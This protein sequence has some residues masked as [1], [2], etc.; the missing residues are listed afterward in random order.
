MNKTQFFSFILETT[1][2]NR[3]FLGIT[4]TILLCIACSAFIAAHQSGIGCLLQLLICAVTCIIIITYFFIQ[5]NNKLKQQQEQILRLQINPHFLF[6]ALNSIGDFVQQNEAV[7]A[8]QYLSS[9]SK[10]MRT[11]LENSTKEQISLKEELYNLELYLQL[12][13]SRLRQNFTYEIQVQDDL[14]IENIMV[15]PMILQP[16]IENSIWH[17]VSKVP[18]GKISVAVAQKGKQLE[19]RVYDNGPGYHPSN[20][21]TQKHKKSLGISISKERI[22]ACYRGL[23]LPSGYFQYRNLARGIMFTFRIPLIK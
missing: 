11:T 10:L 9:F 19:Y 3:Y 14:S 6:N 22:R 18:D 12:E 16:F 7:H 23:F 15:P 4:G 21:L 20:V 5:L 17:A 2:M 13:A 8:D 1:L